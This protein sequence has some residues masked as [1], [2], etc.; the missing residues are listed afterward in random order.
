MFLHSLLVVNIRSFFLQFH[1]LH[2]IFADL[3]AEE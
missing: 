3:V 1:E 2:E